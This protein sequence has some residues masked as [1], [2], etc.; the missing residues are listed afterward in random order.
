MTARDADR[1]R[2][3]APPLVER[4]TRILAAMENL[5]S[6]MFV[7]CGVRTAG[8]QR[9]EFLKG[10]AFTAGSWIVTD[11]HAVVTNADGVVKLSNHQADAGVG[12]SVDCAFLGAE[13][14][15]ETHPWA[16]YGAMGKALGLYW[17][18]DWPGLVD[19]PHLSD[20]RG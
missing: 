17:G 14:Y 20:R 12:H 18:G 6:P 3:V 4:I 1:L 19:R 13:P 11:R 15:A 7:V 5:G 10:R 16:L 9:I 2:G 8:E